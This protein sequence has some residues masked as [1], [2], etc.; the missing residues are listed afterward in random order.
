MYRSAAKK[1]PF[2]T[3]MKIIRARYGVDAAVDPAIVT[4]SSFDFTHRRHVT[5][6]RRHVSGTPR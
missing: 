4:F 1:P 3:S 6:R 2:G 5:P